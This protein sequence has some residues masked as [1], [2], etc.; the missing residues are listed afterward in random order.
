MQTV[1]VNGTQY[2]VSDSVLWIHIGG[3]CGPCVY[4]VWGLWHWPVAAIAAAPGD[5]KSSQWT[6]PTAC[7]CIGQL[8]INIFFIPDGIGFS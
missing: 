8:Q 6:D 5:T 7:L 3:P 4:R 1:R 2:N